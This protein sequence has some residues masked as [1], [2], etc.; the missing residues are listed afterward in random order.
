MEN[1][2]RIIVLYDCDTNFL[3]ETNAPS[4]EIENAISFKNELLCNDCP[5]FS[6]DF[7][8]IQSFLNNKGYYFEQ[9]G[10]VNDLESYNW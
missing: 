1:E 3:V 4:E 6:S 5:T 10:Y 8:E 9:I 2:M 7:E